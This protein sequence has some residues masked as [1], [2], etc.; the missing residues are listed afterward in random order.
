M[1]LRP[2]LCFFFSMDMHPPNEVP[3]PEQEEREGSDSEGDYLTEDEEEENFSAHSSPD[4]EPPLM[5]SGEADTEP[6]RVVPWWQPLQVEKVSSTTRDPGD[7]DEEN[8]SDESSWGSASTLILRDE[9]VQF[10]NG[11]IGGQ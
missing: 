10:L 8:E 2:V 3:N 9:D 4:H 7:S 6:Y 5:P 11:E 1:L